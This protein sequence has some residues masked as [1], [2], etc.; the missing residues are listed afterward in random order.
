MKL[1]AHLDCQ[2][3]STQ[4]MNTTAT[5]LLPVPSH[6]METQH[7]HLPLQNK[8]PKHF[9]ASRPLLAMLHAHLKTVPMTNHPN[10]ITTALSFHLLCPHSKLT[11]GTNICHYKQ[12]FLLWANTSPTHR[13][14]P[15]RLTSSPEHPPTLLSLG[16]RMLPHVG[17]LH[18][19]LTTNSDVQHVSTALRGCFQ[20]SCPPKHRSLLAKVQ[21]YLNS[22]C[23]PPTLRTACECHHNTFTVNWSSARTSATSWQSCFTTHTTRYLLLREQVHLTT[24]LKYPGH[25]S[26]APPHFSVSE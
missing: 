6:Q 2:E 23:P 9:S 13:H 19:T 15:A 7:K 10:R 12:H 16:S 25:S 14:L 3:Q 22:C 24:H 26:Q 17:P 4:L 11:H 18:T 20:F 8:P 21:A 5:C 1:Q